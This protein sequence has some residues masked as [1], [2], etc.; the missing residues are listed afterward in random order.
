MFPVFCY[1]IADNPEMKLAACV[2]DSQNTNMPCHVCYIPKQDS[3]NPSATCELRHAEES[4]TAI[5]GYR[6]AVYGKKEAKK[7]EMEALSL[8]GTLSTFYDANM[9]VPEGIHGAL[10]VDRT[11]HLFLGLVKTC[12]TRLFDVICEYIATEQLAG[13]AGRDALK[14]AMDEIDS[15]FARILRFA[16]HNG[17]PYRNFPS[18]ISDLTLLH[19]KDYATI[20][21]W[22][23][24]V[25]DLGSRYN[26]VPF[27]FDN[28]VISS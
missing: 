8:N 23:P 19:A 12:T 9:G 21:Q 22:W 6:D 24:Y 2:K 27:I 25:F 10:P 7:K 4:K 13:R 20:A 15:R 1:M 11:H 18:G 14:D 17:A 16:L 28:V 5:E 3:D 26:I